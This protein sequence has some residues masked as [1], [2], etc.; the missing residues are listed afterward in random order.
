MVAPAGPV[1]AEALR[2]TLVKPVVGP[3]AMICESTV[4][5][6]ALDRAM[7]EI[8]P[9]ASVFPTL[10]RLDATHTVN[11]GGGAWANTYICKN[12]APN[13]RTPGKRTNPVTK[14][15]LLSKKAFLNPL[16]TMLCFHFAAAIKLDVLKVPPLVVRKCFFGRGGQILK[17][18]NRKFSITELFVRASEQLAIAA[19]IR[20]D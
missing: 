1:S 13:T 12:R 6:R 8:V 19:A 3:C 9:T 14:T 2:F 11:G 4:S 16:P 7:E 20:L 18:S 10:M 5:P 17:R 15:V